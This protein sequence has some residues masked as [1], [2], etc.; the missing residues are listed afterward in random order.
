MQG[1]QQK[2][3]DE[4]KA[5]VTRFPSD[6]AG[7]NNLALCYTQLRMMP[8]A[9]EEM[10]RAVEIAPRHAMFRNN[11]ALFSAYSGDFPSAD[12]SAKTA[13]QL[14][15]S[16]AK[17]YLAQ[18]FAQLAQGQVAEAI[19]TYR[20]LS[21]LGPRPASLAT[22]AL[23]DVSIYG[24][25]YSDAVQMLEKAA[26]VDLAAA[27]K[28]GAATKFVMLANAHLSRGQAKAATTAASTALTHSTAANIRLL[29]A[30]VLA[31]G[32]EVAKAQSVADQ[33]N[34]E[35]GAESQAYAKII[36]GRIAMNQGKPR[37]AAK[38]ISG[39]N[40]LLDTWIGRYDAGWAYLQAGAF[41][42]ADSE[43]DQ[44]IRRKGEAL[45][46]FVDE[47]P[48]YGYFPPVY[49]SI[50]RVREALQSSRFADSYRD[51]LAIRAKAGEDPL[52]AEIRGRVGN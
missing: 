48:T 52:L 33:L 4:Y 37:V 31:S 26:A 13:Q 39:A 18:G 15:P 45:S 20:K 47:V 41:A 49:Y 29:A 46:L 27:D 51:Y 19:D 16:Y 30:R 38:I 44:C 2:C 25:R 21:Q 34:T 9:I 35:P 28:D 17:S 32:G 36:E 24:G 23:A 6:T 8:Q 7:H 5:L 10:R 1:D 50:G 11:L 40:R 42:E 12:Q 43:F 22:L 3:V 14:N